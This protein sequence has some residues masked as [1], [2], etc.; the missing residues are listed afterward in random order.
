MIGRYCANC[1]GR[2]RENLLGAI[3]TIMS[4]VEFAAFEKSPDILP[5]PASALA[6]AQQVPSNIAWR[7]VSAFKA[8]A[9]LAC[10]AHAAPKA[11]ALNRTET[12]DVELATLEKSP[13]ILP[14]PASAETV[15]K[16][17]EL[18]STC[19]I[20][21]SSR[22]R[23]TACHDGSNQ[24]CYG[25][26]LNGRYCANYIGRYGENLPG[27]VNETI[28]AVELATFEK[29]LDILPVPAGAVTVR[30]APELTSTCSICPSGHCRCTACKNGNNQRWHGPCLNGRYCANSIGCYGENLPGTVH[31]TM[32]AVKLATS[33]KSPDI[34]P[35]P[36][37]AETVRNA[38]E[39]TSTCSIE[40]EPI[41]LAKSAS[42]PC[43]RS[44]QERSRNIGKIIV[45]VGVFL[46]A[47]F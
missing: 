17:P 31:Q 28:S 10:K 30:K 2:Y 38:P 15:R 14:V 47:F 44:F 8:S 39:L 23:C 19:S 1:S 9:T 41:L 20:C 37:S 27:T 33:E 45:T 24:R 6:P 32:S 4:A 42:Q 35:V 16:A 43:R 34:P 5:E 22:C 40:C 21:P 29:T 46:A 13:D 26:C 36:A 3:N 11:S 12:S 18:A 25:Q 7:A